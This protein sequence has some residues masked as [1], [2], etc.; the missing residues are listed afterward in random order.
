MLTVHAIQVSRGA[1]SLFSE[2]SFAVSAGQLLVIAG[3]NGVGKSSLLAA[4]VGLLT[5]A[6]GAIRR[7]ADVFY[8]GHK[9]GLRHDLTV[10]ENL[11]Q[12]IRY[13]VDRAQL[14]VGLNACGLSQLLDR[15]LRA[16][17]AGQQQ[18]V[19]L[20]KLWLTPA[21]LWVLDE[22]LEAL[23][24][25]MRAVIEAHVEQH[26]VQGGAALIATHIPLVN[27]TMI[28]QTIE[29]GVAHAL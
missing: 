22:P 4:A 24:A 8:L 19:A 7:Q 6:A 27:Q 18:R 2:V 20:A 5:P 29:L 9:R 10:L 28:T 15:P 1:I 3:G 14:A 16:L 11:Q 12:D 17:S 13:T 21:P 25:A 23:D 26:L